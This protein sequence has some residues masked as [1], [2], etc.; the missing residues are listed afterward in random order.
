[1]KWI[2]VLVML[3]VVVSGCA[4]LAALMGGDEPTDPGQISTSYKKIILQDI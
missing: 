3:L 4:K 1:M 2:F